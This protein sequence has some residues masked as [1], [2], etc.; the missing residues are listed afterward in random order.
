MPEVDPAL[1]AAR[2]NDG[3]DLPRVLGV[4]DQARPGPS[5]VLVGGMHGNE[6][7][8]ALAILRVLRE[9]RLSRIPFRGRLV[10]VVGNREALARGVRF[11]DRD[12]NRR[13][14]DE[15]LDALREGRSARDRTEDREQRELLAVFDD[16][17]ARANGPVTFVDLHTTSGR[18]APFVCMADVLRNRRVALALPVP[19]ILGLEEVIDGSMLGW[20]TDLGHSGAAIE[21]GQHEDPQAVERHAAAAWI[22]LAAAGAISEADAPNL[23]RHRALL[24][25]ATRSLPHVVEIRHR[26]V[27]VPGDGFRMKPGF[28]SFDHVAQGQ[29]LAADRDGTIRALEDGRIL[30]PRYQGQ[31]EDGFFLAGDVRPIWLHLSAVLRQLHLDRI[32]PLLPGVRPHD[33][34]PDHHVLDPTVARWFAVEVMHLFGYRRERPEGRHLVFSRRAPDAPSR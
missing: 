1:E 13:W 29:R 20:L 6:P 32:V 18:G 34:L 17:I 22:L 33:E 28:A 7:A 24:R 5:V 31:G 4:H 16:V 25:Q 8:G 2:T 12:L 27:V 26:H 19:V 9:L 30:L 23:P 11:V 14:Y 3:W 21:A 10:G 15:D